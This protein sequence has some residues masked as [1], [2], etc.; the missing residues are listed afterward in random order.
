M[1]IEVGDCMLSINHNSKK[2]TWLHQRLIL[3]TTAIFLSDMLF[4]V[5]THFTVHKY[6]VVLNPMSQNGFLSTFSISFLSHT[7]TF[8]WT[9]KYKTLQADMFKTKIISF[10]CKYVKVYN[11]CFNSNCSEV[12]IFLTFTNW[13]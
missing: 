8:F 7:D 4:W 10:N 1:D 6:M 9:T 11:I 12:Y 3:W 5:A 2:K 13:L